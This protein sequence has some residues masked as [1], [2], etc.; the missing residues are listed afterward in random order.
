M[1]K[2]I[3]VVALVGLALAIPGWAINAF[4]SSGKDGLSVTD[5][6]VSLSFTNNADGGSTAFAARWVVVRS[7]SSSASACH[8]RVGGTTANATRN[9]R[10]APGEG[11]TFRY[12]AS[13]GGD[14]WS[15]MA[16]ICDTAG[17]ATWDVDAGR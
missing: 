12:D 6:N 5:S 4:Y 8:V 17:T 13:L 16:R 15:T 10:V 3:A 7:R 2:L 14:G 1:R 9:V 11:F